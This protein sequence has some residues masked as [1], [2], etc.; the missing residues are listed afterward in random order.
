[1]F[2]KFLFFLISFLLISSQLY[3]QWVSLDH[4]KATNTPPVVKILKDDNSSTIIQ[5]DI[6]GFYLD[7]HIV[8]GQTFQSADLL[9]EVLS[10]KPGYPELPYITK[11]LAIPDQS[12]ISVEVIE[13]GEIQIIDDVHLQP[14]RESWFE[15]KEESPFEL[16]T[17]VY[18]STDVFPK[19]Y[20]Q[21]DPPVVFRDFRIARI[22]IFPI[23]YSPVKNELQSIS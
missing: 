1:M 9:T 3:A 7:E 22:S 2:K 6:A 5:I 23:R 10:T 12:G 20:A 16:D 15:G 17:E 14:A 18:N 8:K 11:I 4:S 19:E 21:I 13:T